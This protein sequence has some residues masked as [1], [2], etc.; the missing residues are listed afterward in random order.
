[1]QYAPGPPDKKGYEDFS[2]LLRQV[3]STDRSASSAK[4]KEKAKEKEKE[5]ELDDSD[6]E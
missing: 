2:A 6:L 1:M 3:L 4:S 5:G